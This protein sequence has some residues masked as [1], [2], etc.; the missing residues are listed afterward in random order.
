MKKLRD[1]FPVEEDMGTASIGGGGG[2]MGT[3]AIQNFDPV[4]SFK[5]AAQNIKKKKRI[6]KT[7]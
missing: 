1:I 3:Q 2:D 4:I 5:Q 6:N 7:K